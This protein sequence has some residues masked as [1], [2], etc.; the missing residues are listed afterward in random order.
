MSEV[1]LHIRDGV[2]GAPISA[3]VAFS[4]P[5]DHD[6]MANKVGHWLADNWS[7]LVPVVAITH[8]MAVIREAKSLQLE[9]EIVPRTGLLDADGSAIAPVKP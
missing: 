7:G 5:D 6:S 1:I 8:N 3:D 4:H 2:D 9:R